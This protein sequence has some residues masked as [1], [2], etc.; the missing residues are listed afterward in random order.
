MADVYRGDNNGHT[1]VAYE[2]SESNQ[3]DYMLTCC[4]NDELGRHGAKLKVIADYHDV[5]LESQGWQRI[6]AINGGFFDPTAMQPAGVPNWSAGL[7]KSIAE[8]W[9]WLFIGLWNY[10][11]I[12]CVA[13]NGAI[14]VAL[15][16]SDYIATVSSRTAIPGGSGLKM[17]GANWDGEPISTAAYSNYRRTLLGWNPSTGKVVIAATT[18]DRDRAQHRTFLNNLGCTDGISFD[19]GGSTALWYN[20][21]Y[22]IASSRPVKNALVLYRRLKGVIPPEPPTPGPDMP[23]EEEGRTM[24][25]N[26]EG[27]LLPIKK[28]AIKDGLNE[29]EVKRIVFNDGT[30]IPKEVY[31]KGSD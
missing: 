2:D 10:E 30:P 22:I 19:G 7:Q 13:L 6:A 5:D 9:S 26:F 20:G 23:Q 18:Q 8:D 24:W 16:R 12:P 1:Y 31:K 28:I 17:N 4:G 27:K 3:Y 14:P 21:G 15:G 11:K 25:H 29:R